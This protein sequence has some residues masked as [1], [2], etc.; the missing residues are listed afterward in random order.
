MT[1]TPLPRTT[2][3]L[4]HVIAEP[5]WTP[6]FELGLETAKIAHALKGIATFNGPPGSG[7]TTTAV[8][9]AK[10]LP[11]RFVYTKLRH[12]AGT[13][14]VLESVY[15]ALH[16]QSMSG[17]LREADY[18]DA[19]V[20]LLSEGNVGLI[21]DEVHYA[22]V[23]GLIML[24]QL[25]ESVFCDTGEGFPM[26]LVGADVN[27]VASAAGELETRI[28]ARANFGPLQGDDLISVLTN[29]DD[30]FAATSPKLLHKINQAWAKGLL[31]RWDLFLTVV[32]LNPDTAGK[33]ITADEA[34]AFLTTQGVPVREAKV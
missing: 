2:T 20:D 4:P 16:T 11:T 6:D 31:R 25:W 27:A 26:L 33:P 32:S 24:S 18:N 8:T 21:C 19:C 14:E 30:R 7:K 12:R 13:K 1:T 15:N 28:K 22:G 9:A 5:M 23:P 3:R 29:W 10:Q 34:R 17:R